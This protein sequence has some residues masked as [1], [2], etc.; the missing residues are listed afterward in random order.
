MLE[1]QGPTSAEF[2]EVA[3]EL[4]QEQGLVEPSA[5]YVEELVLEDQAYTC[6]EISV[7]AQ[8]VAPEQALSEPSDSGD[9][10]QESEDQVPDRKAKS[11]R[12]S[13]AKRQRRRIR[14]QLEEIAFLDACREADAKI[15]QSLSNTDFGDRMLGC[16]SSPPPSPGGSNLGFQNSRPEGVGQISSGKELEDQERQQLTQEQSEQEFRRQRRR[17]EN[18]K[19]FKAC[20][21]TLLRIACRTRGLPGTGPRSELLSRLQDFDEDSDYFSEGPSDDFSEVGD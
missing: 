5:G 10:E 9:E 3:Q 17:E 16:T 13:K 7:V 11:F 19:E 15:A 6:S 14:R 18:L 1:D 21:T 20:K 4:S 8:D 12:N 2:S